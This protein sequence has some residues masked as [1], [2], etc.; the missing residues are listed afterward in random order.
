MYFV[1]NNLKNTQAN[2]GVTCIY[3]PKCT[4]IIFYLNASTRCIF[5]SINNHKYELFVNKC[6]F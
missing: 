5:V 4:N 2:T 3:N 1:E 6:L